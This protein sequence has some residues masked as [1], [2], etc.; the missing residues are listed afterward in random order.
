MVP[1]KG[2]VRNRNPLITFKNPGKVYRSKAPKKMTDLQIFNEKNLWIHSSKRKVESYFSKSPELSGLFFL[3]K[4]DC[5]K[6]NSVIQYDNHYRQSYWHGKNKS[7]HL[8]W[9]ILSWIIL[10]LIPVSYFPVFYCEQ[11][12][13]G[14]LEQVFNILQSASLGSLSSN[15][16]TRPWVL[17]NSLETTKEPFKQVAFL[18]GKPPLWLKRKS[19]LPCT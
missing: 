13:H 3:N 19:P 18:L 9:Y 12:Y 16:K 17:F 1:A 2:G 5:L 7:N 8:F 6:L 11:L 10:G 4:I 14:P 15:Q